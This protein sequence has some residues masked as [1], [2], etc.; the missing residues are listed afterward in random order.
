ME[1]PRHQHLH[2]EWQEPLEEPCRR[3]Q[4][5]KAV[6]APEALGHHC[7]LLCNCRDELPNFARELAGEAN[8]EAGDWWKR[9]QEGEHRTW[10]A[11]TLVRPAIVISV[12][13]P[14]LGLV[15]VASKG[16]KHPR[17]KVD[18][19]PLRVLCFLLSR[20]QLNR[21]PPLILVESRLPG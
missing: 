5:R 12:H 11:A 8:A 7:T 10:R 21:L 2:Q 4:S 19:Q 1:G 17:F 14:S 15:L 9:A 6:A 16:R 18:S 13:P 20:Y 3:Q